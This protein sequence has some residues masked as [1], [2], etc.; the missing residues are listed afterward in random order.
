MSKKPRTK[1]EKLT[2]EFRKLVLHLRDLRD[3]VK[4]GKVPVDGAL[5][6]IAKYEG[7]IAAGKLEVA[8]KPQEVLF[9]PFAELFELAK[10]DIA[11]CRQ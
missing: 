1:L 9:E 7:V 3:Q 8:G 4:E 5:E 6:M 10:T 2:V 11:Q